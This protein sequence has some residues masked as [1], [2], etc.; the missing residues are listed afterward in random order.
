MEPGTDTVLDKPESATIPRRSTH[1][2]GMA[3]TGLPF[4]RFL[5]ILE[6]GMENI[7]RTS[8]RV[9][10]KE[11]VVVAGGLGKELIGREVAIGTGG[12]VV[13]MGGTRKSQWPMIH[14]GGIRP[15]QHCIEKRCAT[16]FT[17]SGAV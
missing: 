1:V 15:M 6:S 2:H 3:G 14:G 7:G 4:W 11:F 17:F 5:V 8:R 9:R 16:Y 12:G 13:N 10:V